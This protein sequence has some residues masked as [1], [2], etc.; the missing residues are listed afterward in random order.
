MFSH[1]VSARDHGILT[2]VSQPEYV[3]RNHLAAQWPVVGG[4][5]ACLHSL[6][7]VPA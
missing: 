1:N 3:R 4:A 2:G 7:M 6:A 5:S